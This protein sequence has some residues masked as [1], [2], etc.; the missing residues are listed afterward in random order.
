MERMGKMSEPEDL[1]HYGAAGVG[2][3]FLI[4]LILLL[5][6]AMVYTGWNA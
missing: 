1:E 4:V 6:A 5:I 2:I 3:I